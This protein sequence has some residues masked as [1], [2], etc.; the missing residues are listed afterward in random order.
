[1]GAL[2]GRPQKANDLPVGSQQRANRYT[3]EGGGARTGFALAGAAGKQ[4]RAKWSP[5]KKLEQQSTL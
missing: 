5:L 3:D 1:M 4:Q 2:R